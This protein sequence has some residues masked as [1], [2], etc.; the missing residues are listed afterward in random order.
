MMSHKKYVSDTLQKC[1]A[2]VLLMSVHNKSFLEEIRKK[3]AIYG[4]NKCLILNDG[5]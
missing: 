5:L 4:F 2:K 3:S 1:L